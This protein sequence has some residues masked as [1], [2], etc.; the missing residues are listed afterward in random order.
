MVCLDSSDSATCH[1]EHSTV[2]RLSSSACIS[3]LERQYRLEISAQTFVFV[4]IASVG[5]V[6]LAGMY[7]LHDT[8]AVVLC[9]RL[10]EQ[11][12]P[13]SLPHCTSHV[14]GLPI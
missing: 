9:V 2:R 11:L 1:Q 10:V 7:Q 8:A 14:A 3:V 12:Q 13:I 4:G 6:Y 5:P